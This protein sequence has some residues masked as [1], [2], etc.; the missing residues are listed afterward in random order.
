MKVLSCVSLLLLLGCSNSH[1]KA[2]DQPQAPKNGYVFGMSEEEVYHLPYV[3]DREKTNAVYD[4]IS[5]QAKSSD[6]VLTV[7]IKNTGKKD[8][9]L[10]DTGVH[11]RSAGIPFYVTQGK[12]KVPLP[13]P[14]RLGIAAG[15][16]LHVSCPANNISSHFVHIGFVS[17]VVVGEKVYETLPERKVPI[18]RS[19]DAK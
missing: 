1:V 3:L 7:T 8:I 16:E 18:Q 11:I 12:K 17:L 9:V 6:G 2:E 4:T 14:S 10:R 15:E 13:L 19:Q 5:I